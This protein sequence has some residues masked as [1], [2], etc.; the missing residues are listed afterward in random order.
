MGGNPGAP[1][2]NVAFDNGQLNASLDIDVGK[3]GSFEGTIHFSDDR[4][5]VS[6]DGDLGLI[7]ASGDIEV[8]SVDGDGGG[9]IAVDFGKTIDHAM[10]HA[11][12]SGKLT[13]EAKVGIS[14]EIK[15]ET[16]DN[17]N[18]KT[19]TAVRSP[20]QLPQTCQSQATSRSDWAGKSQV[21]TPSVWI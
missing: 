11:V 18:P 19:T 16:D 21:R 10:E 13:A 3:V 6:V 12:A 5:A 4:V 17:G 14:V 9:S 8:N 1:T 15:K 20:P 2:V 7:S